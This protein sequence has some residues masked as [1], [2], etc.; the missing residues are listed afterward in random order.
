MGSFTS[1]TLLKPSSNTFQVAI[2]AP[3]IGGDLTRGFLI[4][5]VSGGGNLTT[6]ATYLARDNSLQ[7]PLTGSV[8]MCTGMPAWSQDLKGN[9]LDLYPGKLV[10]VDEHRNLPISGHEV[11]L[12]YGRQYC[13]YD[14]MFGVTKLSPVLS[15]ADIFSPNFTPFLQQHHRDLPPIY[16]QACGLDTWRDSAILYKYLV[17][18]DGGTLK[19]DIYPGLPHT[20]WAFYPELLSLCEKWAQDLV[21]GVRWLLERDERRGLSARL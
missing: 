3:S 4:A 6:S 2:N 16:Y 20:F 5:G 11:S 7:P 18:K 15:G 12:A 14:H 9:K 13:P 19:L 10:S 8:L 1:V 17:E 21:S